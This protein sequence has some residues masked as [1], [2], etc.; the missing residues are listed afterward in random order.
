MGQQLLAGLGPVL[1]RQGY[2]R[3]CVMLHGSR[4]PAHSEEDGHPRVPLLVSGKGREEKRKNCGGKEGVDWL[5]QQET[6]ECTQ[7]AK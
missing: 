3:S 7:D 2:Q 5:C 4:D 6:P 1:D